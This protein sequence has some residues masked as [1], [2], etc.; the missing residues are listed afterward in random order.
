[1]NIVVSSMKKVLHVGEDLPNIELIHTKVPLLMMQEKVLE[2]LF[3]GT[4]LDERE[5]SEE[6]ISSENRLN[7]G[8]LKFRTRFGM[9]LTTQE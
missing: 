2:Y 1:M 6:T 8:K 5:S 7:M 4:H 3:S 9:I